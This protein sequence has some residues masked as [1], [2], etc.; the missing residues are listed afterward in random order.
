[1]RDDALILESFVRIA[2]ARRLLITATVS[3]KRT[4]AVPEAVRR[5][6]PN[7][8]RPQAESV[9]ELHPRRKDISGNAVEITIGRLIGIVGGVVIVSSPPI[10]NNR[11]TIKRY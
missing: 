10:L 5:A 3:R 7:R 11:P 1:M 8:Q 9:I 4:S 2:N 6:V